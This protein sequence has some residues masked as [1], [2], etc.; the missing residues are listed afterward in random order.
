MQETQT[1]TVVG[2]AVVPCVYI[3]L[4]RG[5]IEEL[6]PADSVRLA[7]DAVEVFLGEQQVARFLARDV[8]FCSHTDISPFPFN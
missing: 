5:D 6:R 8:L 1:V 7:G 4:I 3:H 2:A